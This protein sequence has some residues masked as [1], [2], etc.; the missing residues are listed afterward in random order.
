MNRTDNPSSEIV[1]SRLGNVRLSH[2]TMDRALDRIADWAGS[3]P[4]RLVVTPNVDHIM[5]LQR[6]AAFQEVYERAD[7]SLADGMPVLWAARW[8]GL[9]PLEKVSGSDLVPM[10]CRRAATD[11]LRAFFV[12]GRNDRELQECL[13]QIGKRYEGLTVGGFCPPLGFEKDAEQSQRLLDAIVAYAPDILFFGCGAPKSEIWMDRHRKALSRGVGLGIG[14]GLRFLAGL[15]RRAPRWMQRVG[16]EWSWRMMRE[17]GRLWRRY[18][19]DDM[20]F[21]PLVW[22]WKRKKQR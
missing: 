6:D 11:R 14:A 18:L 22:R 16:L 7:L 8:L 4:F 3:D 19:V 12:G 9:P 15:E 17:P 10:L 21:F 1:W 5:T 20:K 13:E 2:V